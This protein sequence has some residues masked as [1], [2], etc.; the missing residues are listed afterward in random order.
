MNFF[1]YIAGNGELLEFS[2]PQDYMM[3]NA[4]IRFRKG[5]NKLVAKRFLNKKTE[6]CLLI[7]ILQQLNA[8]RKNREEHK[9]VVRFL[10]STQAV[11]PATTIRD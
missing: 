7:F 10:Y 11:S 4:I 8:Q 3:L 5:S 6:I 2:L 1:F 9:K